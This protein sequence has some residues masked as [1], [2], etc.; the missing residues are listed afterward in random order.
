MNDQFGFDLNAFG[1]DSFAPQQVQQ[2]PQQQQHQH[3]H[4]HQHAYLSTTNGHQNNANGPCLDNYDPNQVLMP[5][6]IHTSPYNMTLGGQLSQ[7][8]NNNSG[9]SINKNG[10]VV[11][12]NHGRHHQSH[13]ILMPGGN[14]NVQHPSRRTSPSSASS[15]IRHQQQQQQQQQSN[16]HQQQQQ[17]RQQ[18]R[19]QTGFPDF[20]PIPIPKHAAGGSV[21]GRVQQQLQ[22]TSHNNSNTNNSNSLSSGHRGST[23]LSYQKQ[24]Q[25]SYHSINDRGSRTT[26]KASSS[27]TSYFSMQSSGQQSQQQNKQFKQ[28]QQQQQQQQLQRQQRKTKPKEEWLEKIQAKVSGVSLE[29]MSGTQ[30]IDLLRK[31]ANEVLT[32]YLPCVDFLVQCQQELRKGLQVATTKRYVNHGFRDTYTPRQFYQEYISQLPSRFYQKN[33][34]VMSKENIMVAVKE[35]DKL[36][37]NAKGAESQGCEAV[38]NTFLGGMKD[39]ES[40]GLRKWLSKQGGALH[41]CNDTECLS[42]SCQKLDREEESTKKLAERLRPLAAAALKKLKSEIPA[43]YQEQSSAHPYLPFFHRLECALRGMAN[44]DPEDDDVICIIDDDEV[45]ELKAKASTAPPPSNKRKRS[46]NEI[47]GSSSEKSD[48]KRKAKEL[49]FISTFCDDD[50]DIEV[51]D[52]KPSPKRSNAKKAVINEDAL[53]DF[54]LE[55]TTGDAED[56]SDIMQALLKTLDDVDNED[57]I[58]FDVFEQK[59]D[60]DDVGMYGSSNAIKFNTFDLADG[61]EYIACL[62]DSNNH[63]TVRPDEIEKKS[64]WN[65][66]LQYASAIRLFCDILRSPDCMDAYLESVNEDELIQEGKLPYAE[67]VRH[68]L[69]FRDIVT[70]LFEDYNMIENNIKCS[71]GNL[72]Y[73]TMLQD[74]NMWE[75]KDLLQAIDL[76]FLNSLAYGKAND[77]GERTDMRSRT[78]KLRKLLWAGIK[79]IVDD[80]MPTSGVEE[81]R[82]CTP[83]RRGESSGFVVKKCS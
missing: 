19:L 45:E 51:L 36:V 79:D 68:P 61:L 35:L 26:A 9:S 57:P 50:S 13:Q 63:E 58:N 78:N 74:W 23:Q 72:P 25:Q 49:K 69:C 34:R 55:G 48:A 47:S 1:I 22:S 81:R 11:R 71:D 83:T 52:K 37:A 59:S 16:Q 3:Q 73:E 4:Q 8:S 66:R 28:L 44:F 76:V 7:R 41:I 65:S 31:R 33:V 56:E 60:I 10:G 15:H 54:G 14:V 62:F 46:R 18:H 20:E 42:T 5:Q 39:G 43:S 67:I 29:P 53:D 27:V 70:S 30:I 80:T 82:R 38:K 24:Q 17:L 64:F 12:N 6:P 32:R 77:G 75:G 21:N 40:W 2:Q